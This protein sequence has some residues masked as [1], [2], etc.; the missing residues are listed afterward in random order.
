MDRKGFIKNSVV[1]GIGLSTLT[2]WTGDSPVS[3]RNPKKIIVAGAGIAGLCCAYE[4]MKLGHEVVVLEAAGRYGGTVMTVRD[5]LADALYADYGAENFTKPGY[6][7]YW[8]YIKEFNIPVLP[9]LHRKNRLTRN[10]DSWLTKTDI[11][12]KRDEQLKKLGGL[13]SRELR[14]L[15]SNS[16]QDLRASLEKFYLNPYLDKFEDEYQPFGIGYDHL[17]EVSISKIYKK[18]GASRAALN[19]LGG[20]YTSALHKMWQSYIKKKRGYWGGDFDLYRIKGG[21]D[22]L[23]KE[24]AKRLGSRIK[25]GSKI[26]EIE[27]TKDGVTVLYR[28]FE[29]EKKITADYVANCLPVSALKNLVIKP[30][31][32]PEKKFIINNIAYEQKSRIVFQTR[33]EFWKE[34]D[35]SINLTFN[36]PHLQTIWQVAEEVDSSRAVLMA[37]AS[38]ATN[39]LRTLETFKELYP[40]EKSNINIEQVLVKDWSAD[41]FTPGCERGDFPMGKLSKFWPHLILPH[42]RI[43]FAGGYADNRS[44]GMEA[45][46]N[47]ANRVASEI[48]Q[49]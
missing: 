11:K 33:T 49:T 17:D 3:S 43:H 41:K 14:S 21:N 39:P 22:I 45:A 8:K 42:G 40:G 2:G 24:F 38:A 44:W 7:N 15:P 10:E 37:K 23:P 31:L 19:V 6:E 48:H 36:H 12:K 5:G 27:D 30:E 25:L 4:L 32:P 35:L 28:E 26:L 13:N 1:A 9:Y 46:T 20:E 18:E 47:S 29:Q 34:D 16:G